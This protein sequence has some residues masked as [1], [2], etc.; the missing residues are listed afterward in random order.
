MIVRMF[1]KLPFPIKYLKGTLKNPLLKVNTVIRVL[2]LGYH[3]TNAFN[4]I[5]SKVF[6]TPIIPSIL[7]S[8][9]MF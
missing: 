8:S 6:V 2:H 5:L 7:Y 4:E 3:P 1:V 9:L